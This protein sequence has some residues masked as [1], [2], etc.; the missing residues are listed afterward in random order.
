MITNL[1]TAKQEDS[2]QSIDNVGKAT[3]EEMISKYHQRISDML[4][5]DKLLHEENAKVIAELK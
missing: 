4:L 2:Q 3:H 1:Q 5:S